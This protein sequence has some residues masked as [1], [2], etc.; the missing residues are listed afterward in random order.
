[1][2]VDGEV[3]IDA[4]TVEKKLNGW[5]RWRMIQMVMACCSVG[6]GFPGWYE[7]TYSASSGVMITRGIRDSILHTSI[8]GS[9]PGSNN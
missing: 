2:S 4:N 7:A 3:K 1:M 6:T 5:W 9:I 8:P